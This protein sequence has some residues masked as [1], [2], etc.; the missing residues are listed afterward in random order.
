[1]GLFVVSINEAYCIAKYIKSYKIHFVVQYATDYCPLEHDNYILRHSF[2][3]NAE[4]RVS[5]LGWIAL[6]SQKKSPVSGLCARHFRP[7]ASAFLVSFF[8]FCY[9]KR[10]P[11]A[12]KIAGSLGILPRCVLNDFFTFARFVRP[13]L[14]SVWTIL[15]GSNNCVCITH[16]TGWPKNN[17]L[18]PPPKKKILKKREKKESAIASLHRYW[19][20]WPMTRNWRYGTLCI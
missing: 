8:F 10:C 4:N 14:L 1:M 18:P 6:G 17:N 12:A 3:I 7:C 11:I 19:S 5:S 2:W 9:M 16:F 20:C 13:V 15:S